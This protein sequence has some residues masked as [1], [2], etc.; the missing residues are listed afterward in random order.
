MFY[1]TDVCRWRQWVSV[2]GERIAG[3]FIVITSIDGTRSLLRSHRRL[4]FISV[5]YQAML[6]P[7]PAGSSMPDTDLLSHLVAFP[8]EY[9]PVSR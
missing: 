1:I 7:L 5:N 2:R 3:G 8:Q 9:P 6:A 4:D